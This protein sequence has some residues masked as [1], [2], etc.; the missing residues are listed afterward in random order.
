MRRRTAS[1][2][3]R[4]VGARGAKGS[5]DRCGSSSAVASRIP[6]SSF[7]GGGGGGAALS[8][9]VGSSKKESGKGRVSWKKEAA[10]RSLRAV[11]A[12]CKAKGG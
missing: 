4:A 7:L 2:S 10:R 3:S 6:S 8:W 5:S 11:G 9:E 1:S 12:T